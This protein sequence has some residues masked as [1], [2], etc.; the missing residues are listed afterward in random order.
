MNAYGDGREVWPW[1]D[2]PASSSPGTDEV[3]SFDVSKL[4]QWEV[5]FSHMT[6]KGLMLHVLTQEQENDQLLDGGA[7][8]P[9]RTLYYRELIA[10]FA[11]HPALVW[12]L[13]EENTNADAERKAFSDFI[14]ALDPYDHPIVVHTFPG[15]KNSVYTP[16]LGH[17]TF[18]GASLQNGNVNQTYNTT[19]T[20]LTNS[21][22]AGRPWIVSL[23]EIG[24]ASTGVTPDG[25]GNNHENVRREG[26][27]GSL[28][29]GG[30][31]SEWYFG[32]QQPHNDLDCEDFTSRDRWWD[33]GR[34]AIEFLHA[35][36][37]I[38]ETTPDDTIVSGDAW[39]LAKAG[40]VYAVYTPDASQQLTLDV[41]VAAIFEVLWF[42][43]RDGGPLQIG[44]VSAVSG[45]GV[46]DLGAPPTAL[47]ED[48]AVLVRRIGDLPTF[49]LTVEQGSG[50]GSYPAGVAVPIVADPPPAGL[51]F[52]QWTGFPVTD[53]FSPSTTLTMPAAAVTVTATYA[54]GPPLPTVASFTLVNADTDADILSITDRAVI[55]LDAFDPIPAFN[56][57]A[58]VSGPA[59]G[60]VV[61]TMNSATAQTENVA[62]YALGGDSPTG[63][64][65]A[66][67]PPLG[68]GDY[69]LTATP[70]TA[71]SGSGSAG[72]ALTVDF[73][74]APKF[75]PGDINGDGQTT[76]ADFSALATTFGTAA[77]A[78]RPAGDLN[79]DGA[80]DLADFA[81]L[82][83]D[84]GCGP[85][86]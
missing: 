43:P 65:S 12:N 17:P 35:Y 21:A 66:L 56:I 77:G 41:P 83:A 16:L 34:H 7:L 8:G 2:Y 11:H 14:R 18:D 76:L 73:R 39:A 28:M 37:P 78:R 81:V 53:A 80:V 54:E 57:R 86:G 69:I 47:A 24:P 44:S 5:V 1:T 10:R 85:A 68:V 84:L 51:A 33:Y 30:W 46:V 64:Y 9:Q 52:D 40:D 15:D 74:V 49:T 63:D 38:D 75:C 55:A 6:A 22:Q 32:Y 26:V 58:N 19:R 62:P 79:G 36:V 27:W 31:G 42:D 71:G 48:W 45:P 23:D 72:N 3:A 4:A 13:G 61:F 70:Y 59:P 25:P 82:A 50:D 60:S 20:W 29:A 67:T